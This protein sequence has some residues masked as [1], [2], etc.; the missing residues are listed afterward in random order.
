MNKPLP[1]KPKKKNP[2]DYKAQGTPRFG[3]SMTFGKKAPPQVVDKAIG[4]A[5]SN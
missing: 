3:G 1:K 4:V 5:S 2:S